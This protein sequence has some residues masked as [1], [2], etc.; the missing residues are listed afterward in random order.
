MIQKI[1][2][3]LLFFQFFLII[4]LFEI[5]IVR[6]ACQIIQSKRYG[7]GT[8]VEAGPEE[9]MRLPDVP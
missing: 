6:S 2:L 7:I 5:F 4:V 1:N 3:S 8:P 9:D